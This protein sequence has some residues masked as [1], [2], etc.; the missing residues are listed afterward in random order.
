VCKQ[1]GELV[2]DN[3][4]PYSPPRHAGVSV[5]NRANGCFILASVFLVVTILLMAFSIWMLALVDY[6]QVRKSAGG[7]NI[8]F[9]VA[10]IGIGLFVVNG[11]ATALTTFYLY[12]RQACPTTP[13][14]VRNVEVAAK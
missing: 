9:G 7:A 12:S 5:G 10:I 3:A 14:N 8:G 1:R 6:S 13:P 2:L 4:E 11:V